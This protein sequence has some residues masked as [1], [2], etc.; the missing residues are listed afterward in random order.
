M[1]LQDVKVIL[2]QRTGTNKESY[3]LA[4][5]NEKFVFVVQN[6][7]N[8]NIQTNNIQQIPKNMFDPRKHNHY[9][10]SVFTSCI[11]PN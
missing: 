4:S 11:D 6:F 7:K 8:M 5:P 9:F 1:Y 10:S 2:Q 3:M